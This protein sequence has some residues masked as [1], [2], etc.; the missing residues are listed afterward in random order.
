VN[1]LSLSTQILDAEYR[2]AILEVVTM[3]CDNLIEEEQKKL[4]KVLQKL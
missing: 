3:T 4:L 2:P 1:E